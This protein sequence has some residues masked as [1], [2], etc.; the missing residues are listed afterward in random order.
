MT[1]TKNIWHPVQGRLLRYIN[2][3][4]KTLNQISD[5]TCDNMASYL[6]VP[7]LSGDS[8]LYRPVIVMCNLYL[9]ISVIQLAWF[10]K[11]IFRFAAKT[12]R[13]RRHLLFINSLCRR[14]T[15]RIA[16]HIEMDKVKYQSCENHYHH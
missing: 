12:H 6:Y 16:A 7:S 4:R 11:H 8:S 15:V 13:L 5:G 9:K 2:L 3:M 14:F 1:I 10:K